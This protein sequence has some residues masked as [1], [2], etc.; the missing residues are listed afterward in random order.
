MKSLA[1]GQRNAS[2]TV[3]TQELVL[4]SVPH[5][6]EKQLYTVEVPHIHIEQMHKMNTISS[7]FGR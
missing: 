4:I 7:R 3:G 2:L 5:Q 6:M 1:V